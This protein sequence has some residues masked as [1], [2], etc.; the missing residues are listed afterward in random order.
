MAQIKHAQK[1]KIEVLFDLQD[2]FVL[3]FTNRTFAEFFEDEL[4]IDIYSNEYSSSGE[5]KASRLRCFVKK[6]PITDVVHV[7]TQLWSIRNEEQEAEV[8][9]HLRLCA[10]QIVDPEFHEARFMDYYRELEEFDI[11]ITDIRQEN[12]GAASEN[13]R[14]ISSEINFDTVSA[15][16][17]RAV[18]NTD[19]DPELSVTSASSTIESICKSILSELDIP[20]PKKQDIQSLYRAVQ[21]PLGLSPSSQEFDA[22]IENDIRQILSGLTAVVNGIGALRTH[23]G[24]AHG[25][26]KGFKR[27]D[28][29]IAKLAV[30]SASSICIFLLETWQKKYPDRELRKATS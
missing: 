25:R 21:E 29:R 10:M 13:L 4:H 28:S 9:N 14:S 6:A 15:D 8:E 27:I 16:L 23:G 18:R 11:L 1:R 2:G 5:S 7:L 24:S 20:P 26:E 30:H 22:L 12:S 17:D 3:D 19:T